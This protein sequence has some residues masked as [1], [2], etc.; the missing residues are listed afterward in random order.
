MRN[1]PDDN[2]VKP[3]KRK[4]FLIC[5]VSIVI[6][7]IVGTTATTLFINSQKQINLKLKADSVL[8]LKGD[9]YIAS[10]IDEDS[11]LSNINSNGHNIYYNVNNQTNSWLGGKTVS[12]SGGGKLIPRDSFF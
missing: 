11:S 5:S 12:L 8:N 1:R 4:K 6:F 2:F 9:S 7:L 3:K 10:I